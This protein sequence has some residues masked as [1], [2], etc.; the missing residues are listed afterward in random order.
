MLATRARVD[1]I[2]TVHLP[3]HMAMLACGTGLVL[4]LATI[5]LTP[6]ELWAAGIVLAF[7]LTWASVVDID[8]FIL[9]DIITLGLVIAGLGLH[10]LGGTS[11]AQ[12]DAAIG[13]I[14]GYAVI[15]LTAAA[16]RRLRGRDGLGLGDA[17]LLAAAGAWLGWIALPVVLLGA[18]TAGLLWAACATAIR[19][20][21][22]LA[23]PLPFGPFISLAFFATWLF[24]G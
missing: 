12:L 4:S 22:G 11:Q 13:A 20:R 16:Y 8:R 9:P 5:A 15:A 7:A 24:A 19:G 18:S 23:A 1:H 17:K 21:A 3:P 10:A 6:P 2:G 14:A